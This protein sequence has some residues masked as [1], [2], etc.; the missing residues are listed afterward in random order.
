MGLLSLTDYDGFQIDDYF[1]F[2]ISDAIDN[3][4]KVLKPKFYNNGLFTEELDK[5]SLMILFFANYFF[6]R[7][8]FCRYY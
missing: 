4:Y 1:S 8:K 5:Y 2:S 3:M 7:L 6:F